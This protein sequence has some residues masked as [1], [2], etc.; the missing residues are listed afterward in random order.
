MDGTLCGGA[1]IPDWA[2][3]RFDGSCAVER[4]LD[5][6]FP[7]RRLV[8]NIAQVG[9]V[10]LLGP[11]RAHGGESPG[12]RERIV[13]AIKSYCDVVPCIEACLWLVDH[14]GNT[15]CHYTSTLRQRASASVSWIG[16]GG[17][18]ARATYLD[19]RLCGWEAIDGLPEP[20][21]DRLA[22]DDRVG[23][24]PP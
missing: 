7:I 22:I 6:E 10:L 11:D 9:W 5:G 20:D 8:D 14:G 13:G 15:V 2:P 18:C 17:A 16:P 1:Q 21:T 3:H 4:A 24:M 12:D 23:C 19:G